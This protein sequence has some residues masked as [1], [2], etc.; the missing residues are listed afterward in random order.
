MLTWASAM[1]PIALVTALGL[2]TVFVQ[3]NMSVSSKHSSYTVL[4]NKCCEI[5]KMFLSFTEHL[6]LD[7]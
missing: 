1:S 7:I 4:K 5:K 3:R 6:F 2:A